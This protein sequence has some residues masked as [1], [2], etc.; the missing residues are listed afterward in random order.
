[1]V[2]IVRLLALGLIAT[3]LAVSNRNLRT[4]HAIEAPGTDF[5]N[6]SVRDNCLINLFPFF[7]PSR[8][9][10]FVVVFSR[11][12]YL[13]IYFCFSTIMLCV[14]VVVA[15]AVIVVVV[16]F[17]FV[18]VFFFF[19]FFLFYLFVCFVFAF[20]FRLC[21]CVCVCVPGLVLLRTEIPGLKFHEIFFCL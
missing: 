11:F 1:M 16:V 12:I 20:A 4:Q 10:L 6:N 19:F 7:S 2:G 8:L 5:K 21:V 13:F 3:C 15:A 17:V 18:V 9:C 14:C